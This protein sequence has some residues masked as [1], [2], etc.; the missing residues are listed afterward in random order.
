K[1]SVAFRMDVTDRGKP[2]RTHKYGLVLSNRSDSGTQTQAGGNIQIHMAKTA[3]APVAKAKPT[4][5]TVKATHTGPSNRSA[6]S[7][8]TRPETRGGARL[9]KSH[10]HH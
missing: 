4:G 1:G 3:A 7:T 8:G 6:T 5:V 2:G 9:D 10:K